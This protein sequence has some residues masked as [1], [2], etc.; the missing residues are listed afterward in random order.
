MK[1]ILMA[2]AAVS[3]L[4]GAVS[5]A[6]VASA[7]PDRQDSRVVVKD[8]TV[9]KLGGDHNWRKG[10]RI[11][12]SDWARG[13]PVDYRVHRLSAPPRGYEWREVDGN[14]V[15]AAVAGGLIASVLL[16]NQ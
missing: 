9:V 3:L 12:Q 15:L 11:E 14:Y 1:R 13:A 10:G 2:A 5:T 4:V 8:R 7:E 6:G 16:A